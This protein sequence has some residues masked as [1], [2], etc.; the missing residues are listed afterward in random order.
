M[1]YPVV[2]IWRKMLNSLFLYQIHCYF[3]SEGQ[4]DKTSFVPVQGQRDK[5]LIYRNCLSLKKLTVENVTCPSEEQRGNVAPFGPS[6][7]KTIPPMSRFFL[8][9]RLKTEGHIRDR[10]RDRINLEVKA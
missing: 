9:T 10:M 2:Q 8:L 3:S 4:R 6:G 5:G 7:D 1:I